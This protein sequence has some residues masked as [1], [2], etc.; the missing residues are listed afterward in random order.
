[1]GTNGLIVPQNPPSVASW[2][3]RKLRGG[4]SVAFG[5]SRPRSEG[6]DRRGDG[7]HSQRLG[8]T[9]H[10]EPIFSPVAASTVSQGRA[11]DSVLGTALYGVVVVAGIDEDVNDA[12]SFC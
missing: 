8:R 9:N 10:R 6:L 11:A 12:I 3:P 2:M 7:G 4:A 1:M 5:E